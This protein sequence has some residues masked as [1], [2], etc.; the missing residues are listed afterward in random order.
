VDV[1]DVAADK[2]EEDAFLL[3]VFADVLEDGLSDIFC[4][5]RLAVLR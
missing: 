2:V 5:I 4:E 1:V 3:R